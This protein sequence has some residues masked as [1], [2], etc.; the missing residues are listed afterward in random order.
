M[1]N[2]A[3]ENSAIVSPLGTELSRVPPPEKTWVEG[4]PRKLPEPPTLA[5]VLRKFRIH[6]NRPL[7]LGR[8][9]AEWL[10]HQPDR[11]AEA[12]LTRSDALRQIPPPW[13]PSSRWAW[14]AASIASWPATTWPASW[15]GRLPGSCAARRLRELLPLFGRR[16]ADET[17]ELRPTKAAATRVLWQR[18]IDEHLTAPQVRQ[19]VRRLMPRRSLPI[20][21]GRHLAAVRR[22]LAHLKSREDLLAV[23]R[24]VEDRLARLGVAPAAKAG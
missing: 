14:P 7:A 18:M 15:A 9:V 21:A 8:F 5:I 22:E 1:E 16:A 19:E 12:Q 23:I 13:S 11:P 20:G 2:S 17:Y 24:L 10:A 3:R 6:E 4:H